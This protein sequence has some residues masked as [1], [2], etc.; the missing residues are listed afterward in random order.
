MKIYNRY[1]FILATLLMIST[2]ILTATGQSSLSAYYTVYVIEAMLLTELYI[3][4][5]SRARRGLG[6]IS[7]FLFTTFM[8]ILS[9]EVVKVLA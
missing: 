4:F 6:F 8:V 9:L 7:G 1:I 3:Y 5:N 2:I